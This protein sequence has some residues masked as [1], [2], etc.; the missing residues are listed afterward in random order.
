M[1]DQPEQEAKDTGQE[2]I[3]NSGIGDDWGEA[4]EAEDFMA[5]P[6]DEPSAEFFLPDE[7]TGATVLDVPIDAGERAATATVAPPSGL[8]AGLQH[9]RFDR[10][11]A[12]P[13]PFRLAAV[14]LPLLALI[15][16]LALRGKAPEQMASTPA[17]PPKTAVEPQAEI[18]A[19]PEAHPPEAHPPE[20]EPSPAVGTAPEAKSEVEA[21]SVSPPETTQAVVESHQLPPEETARES[22]SLAPKEVRKKWR[23]PAII[24]HGKIDKDQAPIIL[25][26]D[27]TLVLK[28]APEVMPPSAKESFIREILYQF[29][30]NQP[31][32]D[33]K[34]YALERGEMNRK[35][36]AW[37]LK[38]WPELSLES[39]AVDR[40]HLL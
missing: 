39:I 7:V 40:Y 5:A 11:R 22:E 20:S 3:F 12:I 21:P 35:L 38:Q 13:L 23:F 27:L 19:P 34:R 10:F 15:L 31:A 8:M 30:T 4:F 26:V 16:F 1:A 29:Y 28:L 36:Q 32:D 25:T 17:T 2:T 9:P 33:L 18:E 24:V 6:S 14:A 37:I